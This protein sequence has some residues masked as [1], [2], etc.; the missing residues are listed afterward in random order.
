MSYVGLSSFLPDSIESEVDWYGSVNA[1]YR[2]FFIST[3]KCWLGLNTVYCVNAL[4]RAFFISTRYEV[5]EVTGK[6]GVCQCPISGFLH[7]YPVWTSAGWGMTECCVNALYRAF[8]I[9]TFENSWFQ[10]YADNCVNA[11]YRAFFIS[12]V[13]N[14][15]EVVQ[16]VTV[17]MPYI[18]LSS[19]LQ[20]PEYISKELNKLCQ[21][22]ISGFLHFYPDL[23]EPLI[24]RGCR[25]QFCKPIWCFS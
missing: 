24:L 12:T 23:W 17:S 1:L 4:Y 22:P 21:C 18:G 14:E 8:F 10:M 19:F 15:K 13:K 3:A 16:A 11:L 25:H 20:H 5:S 7:F 2:A 6:L 9:S